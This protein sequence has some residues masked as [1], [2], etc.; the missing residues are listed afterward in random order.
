VTLHEYLITHPNESPETI[1]EWWIK[2]LAQEPKDAAV[3]DITM[4]TSEEC[5]RRSTCRRSRYSGMVPD[6]Y[7]QSYT[8]WDHKTCTHYWPVKPV[9]KKD[10]AK[11]LADAF[12]GMP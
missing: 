12:V 9:K 3:P 11:E 10:I 8:M 4:C 6:Q 2:E 7:G 5:H 1:V